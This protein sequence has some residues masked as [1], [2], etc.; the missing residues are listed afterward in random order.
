[1]IELV[2]VLAQIVAEGFTSDKRGDEKPYGLV[3]VAFWFV[4]GALIGWIS[5]LI[6][7]HSVIS[8]EWL[9]YLSLVGYPAF[10]GFLAYSLERYRF[11]SEPK[12]LLVLHFLRAFA[13]AFGLLLVRHNH[14]V[15][16]S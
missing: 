10:A 9:R 7:K 11:P 15:L 12:P 14:F 4:A 1:L 5:L 16:P 8:T 6:V 3:F 13:F 2:L